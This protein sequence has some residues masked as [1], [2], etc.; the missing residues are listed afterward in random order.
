VADLVVDV[1]D[2]ESGGEHQGDVDASQQRMESRA[3][4]SVAGPNGRPGYRIARFG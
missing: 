3:R 4:R 2:I 1:A